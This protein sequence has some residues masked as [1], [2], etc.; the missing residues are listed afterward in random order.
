MKQRVLAALLLITLLVGV[1]SA[2]GEKEKE[3]CKVHAWGA[4]QVSIA[5]TE[6]SEGTETRSCQNCGER[7]NRLVPALGPTTPDDPNCE[8]SHWDADNNGKCDRCGTS[9]VIVLDFFSLNDLHGKVA[10]TESQ[11]GIDEL[12]TYLKQAKANNPNTFFLS[13]G[14]MWQGSAESNLTRG[15]ILVDWMNMMGFTSMA[16]GNHE[17]D[18]GEDVIRTNAS[19]SD[20]P[21]LA[22]NVY[23]KETNQRV[24]YAEASTVV[25]LGEVQIGIIGAIGDCYSS[26]ASD[27]TTD[28]YFK[29]GKELTALV[30]AE[31]ERLRGEGVDYIVYCLHDGNENDVDG[32]VRPTQMATYYD[33]ELSNGYIDLVFEGHTHQF[34]VQTDKYGVYHLQN[35]G[36]NKG[37]AHAKVSFN[38]ANGKQ[39]VTARIVPASTYK[40]YTKDLIIEELLLKYDSA[41][42]DAFEVL[43]YNDTYRNSNEI[44]RIVAQ[45]YYEKGVEVWGDTYDIVLGGGYIGVRSPYKLEVGDVTY[46]DLLM[47][48]PFDNELI[49]CSIKGVYLEG[50]FFNNNDYAVGYGAY[51][52]SVKKNID[53][54]KTYYIIVDSYCADYAYNNLTVIDSLGAGIYARDLLADHIRAG[55]LS[56]RSTAFYSEDGTILLAACLPPC[57][58]EKWILSIRPL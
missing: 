9:V 11:P 8:V 19:A 32:E 44:K 35:G 21:I 29:V 41:I 56:G 20:F 17:F 26:I 4:W 7:E 42:G 16:L 13:S 30:K 31:A 5:P 50:R 53:P 38:L 14:D 54:N 58:M 49:L 12:T 15:S 48:L 55:G 47:V 22:I 34:Y 40:T 18:W 24:E 39:E 27:K 2:C 25:D 6:T 10:D 51:G 45:L 46:A 37:V 57:E 36:E 33:S 43:G 3:P 28:V 52:E 23:N 1:F